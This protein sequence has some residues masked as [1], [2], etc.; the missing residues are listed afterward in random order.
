MGAGG[1]LSFLFFFFKQPV[2]AGLEVEE[3]QSGSVQTV[4]VGNYREDRRFQQ[5]QHQT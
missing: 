2:V 3:R 1:V 4:E 5:Q